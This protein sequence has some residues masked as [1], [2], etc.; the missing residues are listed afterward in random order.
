MLSRMQILDFLERAY[1]AG[2]FI[3]VLKMI[4]GGSDAIL[5]EKVVQKSEEK[6]EKFPF[7]F[8]DIF[9]TD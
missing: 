6:A 4:K 8:S 2:C 9:G 1:N 7:D 3:E 5:I